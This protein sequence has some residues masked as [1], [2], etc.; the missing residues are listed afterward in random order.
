MIEVKIDEDRRDEFFYSGTFEI[1]FGIDLWFRANNI[2]YYYLS[3]NNIS[4]AKNE[5][6][7]RFNLKYNFVNNPYQVII[8]MTVGDFGI[9]ADTKTEDKEK[10][11]WLEENN[12]K[13]KFADSPFTVWFE[14][15]ADMFLFKLKW[16]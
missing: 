7:E 4:F 3:W 15:D 10:I 6:A 16:Q 9:I 2:H 5:D 8:P 1:R 11:Y 12:I 14:N 13:Y